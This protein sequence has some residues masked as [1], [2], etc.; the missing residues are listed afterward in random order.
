MGQQGQ[1]REVPPQDENLFYG[2]Y[3][4]QPTL[5][6]NNVVADKSEALMLVKKYKRARFKSFRTRQEATDFALYGAANTSS[7]PTNTSEAPPS[8]EKPSPFRGPKPQDMIRLRKSIENGDFEY[9]QKTV[10]ENPRYLVSSGDT[11]AILQ[12][13]SRYNALH[14]AAK[15]GNATISA[16]ILATVSSPEFVCKLYGDNTGETENTEERCSVLLDLYLNMPD[17]GSNETPLHFATKF[18]AARV[19]Q[20]LVAY[21][22]CNKTARNKFMQTPSDI[23]CSRLNGAEA[24]L[25]EEIAGYLEEQFFVPVLRS[26]DECSP[27]RVGEPFSP[28]SPPPL[29]ET[30]G[31]VKSPTY[32]VQAL[33]GPMPKPQAMAF[34]KRWK[35]PPRNPGSPTCHSPLKDPERGWEKIGRELAH[36]WHVT[37]KEYWPFLNSYTDF[38]TSEG[39]QLLEDYLNIRFK[40]ACQEVSPKNISPN[41]SHEES[42]ETNPLSPMS[43]LCLA[44]KAC[45]LNCSGKVLPSNPF[46]APVPPPPPRSVGL[47]SLPIDGEI[48]INNAENHHN[49]V[50]SYQF[51]DKY[52][53]TF[54][55]RISDSLQRNIDSGSEFFNKEIQ[56]FCNVISSCISNNHFS[57]PD[58]S[59]LHS[60]LGYCVAQKLFELED[61]EISAITKNINQNIIKKSDGDYSSSDEETTF[62]EFYRRRGASHPMKVN[63]KLVNQATICISKAILNSVEELKSC[64][65][66]SNL[67][68]T[69]EQCKELWSKRE[70][71]LCNWEQLKLDR[72]HFDHSITANKKLNFS[73]NEPDETK[74]LVNNNPDILGNC[75]EPSSGEE[76]DESDT[77]SEE[78]FTPPS[79]PIGPSA[80]TSDDDLDMESPDEGPDVYIVGNTPSKLDA[81]VLDAIKS[82]VISVAKYPNI[83]RWRHT[84]LLHSSQERNCWQS[85]STKSKSKKIF[86]MQFTK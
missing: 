15:S 52:C 83:S 39:L 44:L 73:P 42:N 26:D 3:I 48:K 76:S 33:A 81:A 41:K 74:E 28:T 7:L 55:V 65:D 2:V 67:E 51:M 66:I 40:E 77:E 61:Y 53:Q 75:I 20:V 32:E 25:K 47:P 49:I 14:I 86:H 18:G 31:N 63:K 6:E 68:N 24:A 64:N 12:E 45:K 43:E 54:A 16:Y 58:F 9:V 56:Q 30:K 80:F 70:S 62:R 38:K 37:W 13:G 79:S 36:E 22:Q 35:T 82:E 46:R 19:V 72:R 29:M 10:W 60:R 17:K 69:E 71:C 5:E 78:Y 4:P 57:T 8:G 34:R 59:K 23:I 21:P 27:P 85:P 1:S 50:S 11:P 84:V